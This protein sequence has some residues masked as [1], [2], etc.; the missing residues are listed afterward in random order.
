[1]DFSKLCVLVSLCEKS[2]PEIGSCHPM[3]FGF[4]RLF[5]QNRDGTFSEIRYNQRFTLQAKA[6][7]LRLAGAIGLFIPHSI[8]NSQRKRQ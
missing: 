1:M 7:N 2:D 3:N 8:A 4:Q 5:S 6:L